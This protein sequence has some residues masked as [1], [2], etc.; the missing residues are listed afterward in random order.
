MK[1]RRRHPRVPIDWA[2]EV[3]GIESPA[4]F[5]RA[6]DVSE[7]GLGVE[8]EAR[9]A[10]DR[11]RVR[12]KPGTDSELTLNAEV[13]WIVEQSGQVSVG[14]EFGDV[15]PKKRRRLRTLI[16]MDRPTRPLSR[17]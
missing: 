12:L 17:R 13:R 8:M 6:R 15:G 14:L 9:P 4:F 2:V 11:L 5:G 10:V 3:E 16:D 7:S 1:D